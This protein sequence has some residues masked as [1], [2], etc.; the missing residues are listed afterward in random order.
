M[1]RTCLMLALATLATAS[2]SHGEG[3][4]GAFAGIMT[5]F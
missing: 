3:R 1:N 2:Q 4:C 5:Q